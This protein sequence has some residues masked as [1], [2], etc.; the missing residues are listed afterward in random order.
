MKLKLCTALLTAAALLAPISVMAEKAQ[1][2]AAKR[3]AVAMYGKLP[4]SFEPTGSAT[5]FLARSGSYSVLVGAQESSVAVAAGKSGQPQMLRFAFENANPAAPLQA[6]EPQPG[7][8]NYYL[9]RDRSQWRLGVKSFGKLRAQS[10]YPG[11]DVV[12][13][14]DHRRLEF[15]FVVAPK[16]D[17]SAIALSFSGMDKLY[18]DAG[19]DLVAEVGGQPVRFAKPYAYQQ[20]DGASKAVAADYVLSAGGKVHLHLGDYDRNA[21]LIV[22]PVVTYATYLGGTG[23]DVGNGIVVDSTGAAYVTG[24]TC[25]PTFP[26][27]ATANL[28]ASYGSGSCEAYVTKISNGGTAFAYTTIIG[29]LQPYTT[30][31]GGITSTTVTGTAVG[32]GIALDAANQAYIVGSTNFTDLPVTGT[33]LDALNNWQGGDSD[34]FIAILSS[35]TSATPGAVVGLTYLGGSNSDFGYGIAVDNATNVIAVGETCSDDFP[36]YNA[37]ETKVEPCV[38]FVTKLDNGLHIATPTWGKYR[39][40]AMAPTPVAPAG[41]TYYFSEYFGGQPVA[42]IATSDWVASR[43]YYPGSIIQDSTTPIPNIEIAFYG[44]TAGATLP[45]WATSPLTTTVDGTITWENLGPVALIPSHETVAYGVALDPLGDIFV[46]GGSTTPSLPSGVW[47]FLRF[48]YQGTGAWVIKVNG[49]G[50]TA[51]AQGAWVYGTPLESNQTDTSGT[52][53]TARAIAV[54]NSGAAYVTGTA[55]GSIIGTSG[56]SYKAAVTG[57]DDAFLSK[58]ST[59]GWPVEYA[60]YLG[61]SGA[62]Q[63]LGVAV[64]ANGAAY[65]TGSTKSSTDFP[66]I[67]PLLDPNSTPNPNGSITTLKGLQ[68]AFISKFNTEGSALIFSAYLGGSGSDQG[69]AIALDTGNAGNMYVAGTTSSVDLVQNLDPS[70]YIAIAPQK[71]NAGGNSDAFV[72]MVSGASLPTVT[73]SPGSLNYGT[74]GV[75]VTSAPALV[76]YKNTTTTSNSSVNI[77]SIAFNGANPGDFAQVFPGTGAVGGGGFSDCV[78]GTIAAGA[79]CNIWVTFDPTGSQGRSATL[80]ITDDYSTTPHAVS[81]AGNGEYPQDQFSAV[82]LSFAM[83]SPFQTIGTPAPA[84]TETLTNVG[85]GTLIIAN[86]G[87]AITGLNASDFSQSYTCGQQLTYNNNCTIS[88]TFTPTQ[89]GLRLAALTV[90]D[91]SPGSPHNIPL[92]GTGAPVKLPTISPLTLTFTTPQALTVASTSLPVTVTNNDPAVTL[93][94]SAP[95]PTGPFQVAPAQSGSCGTTLAPGGSCAINV[96]FTPTVAGPATGTLSISSNASSTP[97]VVQLTGTGA[98][99]ST[100]GTGTIQLTPTSVA[101][102]NQ[103]EGTQSAV[104][105]VTLTNTGTGVLTIPATGGIVLKGNTD[106][107]GTDNCPATLAAKATCSIALVFAPTGLGV[108]TTTLTVTGSATNSPQSVAITG[109]GTSSATSTGPF[110]VTPQSTGVSVTQGGTATYA[111]SVAPQ[112]G[113]TGAI[114]FAC[115]GLPTGSSYTI[116]PSSLTMDGTTVKTATLSVTTTGGKGASASSRVGAKSIFLALLPFSMMGMLLINKRRNGWLVLGLVALCLLLGLAGCGAGSGS[117]SAGL[118][119]GTYNFTLTATSS[120]SATQTLNLSLVVSAQ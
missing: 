52:I 62:E 38:A 110:S 96:T 49:Q 108:E 120:A 100:S 1:D 118:A 33:G 28:P 99:S 56:T 37:F 32:N 79:T 65:V 42:P 112:S 85:L 30:I 16:A 36:A 15:D 117:S 18:K 20:V 43:S 61:G 114:T 11:V 84:Q 94:L 76:Q 46:A 40:I 41:A 21:E 2:P 3:E 26:I 12:Y 74:Q 95:V 29:G 77:L 54:D 64:D 86:N 34:A 48:T 92:Q 103:Q 83:T 67:N 45:T 98:S 107:S 70:A 53:D 73:V 101:F 6:I 111:L 105:T 44:G 90:T 57:P 97:V 72:A 23:T 104:Q 25:S 22:D 91:N 63:G 59:A 78:P 71:A 55:T 5:H 93:T 10:V 24:Q 13:Y 115:A 88:V 66:T 68:N 27:S 58:I 39:I 81:L 82:S 80:S 109:T 17:P 14:G 116:S 89:S 8:T 31:V 75:G 87:I 47:P 60:T 69:N 102:G 7:V 9:G 35:S 4:L 19:G 113:F 119:P 106:F 50:Q 51:S